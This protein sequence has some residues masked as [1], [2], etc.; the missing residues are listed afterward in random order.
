MSATGGGSLTPT[1]TAPDP[2]VIVSAI[3]GLTD[4]PLSSPNYGST[5][6]RLVVVP[7]TSWHAERQ[8]DRCSRFE[9]RWKLGAPVGFGLRRGDGTHRAALFRRHDTQTG[10]CLISGRFVR[11][12]LRAPPSPDAC[13]VKTTDLSSYIFGRLREAAPSSV[14]NVTRPRAISGR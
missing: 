10:D 3:G 1:A 9:H 12:R 6:R 5:S 2:G 14:P 4:S 7:H 13:L 8:H 11:W